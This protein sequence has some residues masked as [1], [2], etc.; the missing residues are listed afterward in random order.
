MVE[1]LV[2]HAR[3]RLILGDRARRNYF[4]LAHAGPDPRYVFH[5]MFREFLQS[6]ARDML[7]EL[8]END[9]AA[10]LLCEMHD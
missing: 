2:G 3:A 10:T 7:V 8:G 1:T 4:I 9:P 5:A 6:R